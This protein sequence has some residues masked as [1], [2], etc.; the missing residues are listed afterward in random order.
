MDKNKLPTG[1]KMLTLMTG[2]KTVAEREANPVHEGLSWPCHCP[3]HLSSTCS[4]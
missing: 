2:L 3:K 1:K 4:D